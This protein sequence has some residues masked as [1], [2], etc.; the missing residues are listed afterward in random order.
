MASSCG[1][2]VGYAQPQ[3]LPPPIPQPGGY[4]QPAPAYIQPQAGG[5]YPVA[6]VAAASN[7]GPSKPLPA[8]KLGCKSPT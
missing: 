4:A 8:S 5:G 3:A 1:G 2:Q 7:T 6:R